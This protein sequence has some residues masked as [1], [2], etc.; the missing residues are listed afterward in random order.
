MLGEAESVWYGGGG[1]ELGAYMVS[2]TGLPGTKAGAFAC[3]ELRK[4]VASFSA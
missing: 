1:G 4:V 3:I 2:G